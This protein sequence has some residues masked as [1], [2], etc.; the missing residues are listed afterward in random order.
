[1]ILIIYIPNKSFMCSESLEYLVPKG[2]T[3]P[4]KNTVIVH[5][6]IT[7]NETAPGHLELFLSQQAEK[8][9]LYHSE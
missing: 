5:Y 2:R 9:L 8:G 4:L 1:M 6:I 7:C 3:A